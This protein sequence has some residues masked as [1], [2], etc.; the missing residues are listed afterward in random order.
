MILSFADRGTSDLFNRID[1]KS[2]RRTCPTDVWPVARRKLDQINAAV[3]LSSLAF[4]P[5]NRL[6]ALRGNRAGQYS[7]RVSGQ[8]R[9]CFNSTSAGAASV[10]VV[11]Y[12]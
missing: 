4:P 2:A 11:D 6:E 9:V 5:G 12:H 7:I 3:S 10:A 8:W 1:T